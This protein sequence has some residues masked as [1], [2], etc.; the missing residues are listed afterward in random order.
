MTTYRLGIPVTSVPRTLEDLERTT[1]LSSHLVR[2]A[3]RQAE[4]KGYRLEHL[5]TDRTRSDLET[6]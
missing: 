3:T 4:I 1:L 6:L 5:Q 2:R